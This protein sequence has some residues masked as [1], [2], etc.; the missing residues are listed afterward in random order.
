MPWRGMDAVELRL[1]LVTEYREGF[2]SMTE[3]CEEYGVSRKTAYKW[4]E[5]YEATGAAGLIEGSR[6]PHRAARAMDD[7]VRAAVLDA[8]HRHPSWGA[9]KLLAWLARRAPTQDWPG[10]SSVCEL[11]KREGAARA[12]P[13]PAAGA[14]R[15]AA[16]HHAR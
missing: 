16:P 4:L 14:A 15:A 10:R 7:A 6:R 12:P 13:P 5:R 8:R 9:R 3:L 11:L 2:T 1:Q